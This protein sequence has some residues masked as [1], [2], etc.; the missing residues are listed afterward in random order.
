MKVSDIDEAIR[1]ARA[2]RLKLPPGAITGLEIE[3]AYALGLKAFTEDKLGAIKLGGTNKRTRAVFNVS[4]PYWGSL[5]ASEVFQGGA[6]LVPGK[7]IS[8][9]V[10]PE[11]VVAFSRPF[12][13]TTKPRDIGVLFNSLDWVS[14]GLEIPDTVLTDPPTD[15]VQALLADRCAAGALVVGE[16]QKPAAL[17]QLERA[18]AQLEFNAQTVS[19][20]EA[21]CDLIGG[22]LGAVRDAL[23]VLGEYECTVPAGVIISTGGLAPAIPLRE[24]T[25]V[26]ARLGESSVS[27]EFSGRAK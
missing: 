22:V 19:Q 4:R 15:G 11:I 25:F 12:R 26:T 21:D 10:E 8:P 1:Q 18:S 9:S 6:K 7:F 13:A 3:Q 2:N 17:G 20:R 23:T 14:I 5:L 16:R 24:N 27:F